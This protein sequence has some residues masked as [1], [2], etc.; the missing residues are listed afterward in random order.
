MRTICP[1]PP[2]PA[3]APSAHRVATTVQVYLSIHR[4]DL[5][6]KEFDGAKRWAEDDLLLQLIEAALS[7]GTGAD[8]YAD[9]HAF[10]TEQ[11]ANPSLSAPRL[12]TGRG[13]ARILQ[14]EIP[15][16]RSDLEEV[17]KRDAQTL[18]ALVVA[19]GLS[20]AKGEAEAEQLWRCVCLLVSV[21][22]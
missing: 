17:P 12:L 13:V 11:L 8:A 15:A 4:P 22:G 18:A 20:G 6:R 2:P 1:P 14:G 7:L 5:A 3:N 19:A 21:V 10:Y 16:A 9:A